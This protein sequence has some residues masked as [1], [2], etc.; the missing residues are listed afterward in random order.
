MT[1]AATNGATV[2]GINDYASFVVAIL[3]FQMVP[4]PGTIAILN[5]TARHGIKS[6][7]SAVLGTISGD[8]AFMAAA[9]AGLA[10]VLKSH[11]AIFEGL[12]WFGAAYLV[13]VGAN[14]LLAKSSD[15]T[16]AVY[17]AGRNWLFYR[18][19]FAVSVTNPKVILFFVAFF[20]LFLRPDSSPVTLVVMMAHVTVL[21]FAYQAGLVLVGNAVSERARAL[22][23]VR[24]LAKKLAGVAL[25]SFGIKLAVNNR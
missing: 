15:D 1:A 8:F 11:P 24:T 2:F 19:A 7:L 20:P 12:Q 14:L 23:F 10:A 6:G 13:W 22:P 4:G 5:A 25:I 16:A 21:S 3:V 9:V 17:S 18:Q